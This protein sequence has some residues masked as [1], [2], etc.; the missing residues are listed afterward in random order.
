MAGYSQKHPANQN[1]CSIFNEYKHALIVHKIIRSI[2]HISLFDA[3]SFLHEFHPG[4]INRQNSTKKTGCGAVTHRNSP[5]SRRSEPI[6]SLLFSGI[7]CV[8]I[9]CHLKS[10][11]YRSTVITNLCAASFCPQTDIST[12]CWTKL[13]HFTGDLNHAS[14]TILNVFNLIDLCRSPIRNNSTLDRTIFNHL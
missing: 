9:L 11:R 3:Y 12:R 5:W 4:D 6:Y 10:S 14:T 7:D 1:A 8:A 13:L 2:S